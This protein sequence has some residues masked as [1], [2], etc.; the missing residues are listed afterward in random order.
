[1]KVTRGSEGPAHSPTLKEPRPLA[2]RVS[3]ARLGE[4]GAGTRGLQSLALGRQPLE[5]GLSV[6]NLGFRLAPR[7]LAGPI[8]QLCGERRGGPR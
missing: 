4:S 5:M 6:A 8:R 2:A 1:M 3:V 7:S